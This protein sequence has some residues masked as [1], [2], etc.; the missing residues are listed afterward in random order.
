MSLP[1]RTDVQTF[2]DVRRSLVQLVAE[3]EALAANQIAVADAGS[4]FSVAEATRNVE[5]IL[6]EIGTR[7]AAHGI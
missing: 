5:T 6:A 1:V 7:L 4:L 3:I 2:D